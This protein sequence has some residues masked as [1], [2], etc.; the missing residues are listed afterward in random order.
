[1]ELQFE[2]PFADNPGTVTA[3]Q[4]IN[5]K[6]V[7]GEGPFGPLHY[8]SR[9]FVPEEVGT[10]GAVDVEVDVTNAARSVLSPIDPNEC[11]TGVTSGLQST[12]EVTPSWTSGE[13]VTLCT[14]IAGVSKT[15][16][17]FEGDFRA[18]ESPGVYTV[19]VKVTTPDGSGGQIPYE[20][21]VEE[22]GGNRPDPECAGDADC[23]EGEVCVDGECVPED[24]GNPLADLIGVAP[25]AVLVLVLLVLLYLT[26]I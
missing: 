18:P 26:A 5:D 23:P 25:L 20:V 8:V 4:P 22:G 14:N 15:V 12:V 11:T 6:W 9:V 16:D 3:A 2:A 7:F 21:V 10:G 1:M 24:G 19:A 17:T 13:S